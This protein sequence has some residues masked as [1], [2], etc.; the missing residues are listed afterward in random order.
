LPFSAP[1]AV[2]VLL[3]GPEQ[4]TQQLRANPPI[5]GDTSL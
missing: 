5:L 4:Q 1:G 3:Q 2:M